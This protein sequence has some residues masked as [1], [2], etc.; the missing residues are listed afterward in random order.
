MVRWMVLYDSDCG[1][2]LWL[3]AAI[4]RWDTHAALQPLPLQ[5]PDAEQLLSD[6]TPQ[7]R[8][9]SWHLISP[10]G[11]RHSGGAAFAPLLR[12]LPYGAPAASVAA[13]MPKL[14][15]RCYRWV[16]AHRRRLATLVPARSKRHALALVRE[17]EARLSVTA[18]EKPNRRRS[19]WRRSRQAP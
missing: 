3:L 2:C 5:G 13:V 8:M 18:G 7:A 1:L 15:D 4:L 17:R 6:M 11:R 9:A 16:A 12:L 19:R 14:S 10:N